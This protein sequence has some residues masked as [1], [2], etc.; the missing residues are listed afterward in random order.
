MAKRN[1]FLD[2]N[3]TPDRRPDTRHRLIKPRQV[4][5][6]PKWCKR[7]LEYLLETG[8]DQIT[9][10]V[11]EKADGH[12]V[13]FECCPGGAFK[14]YARTETGKLLLSGDDAPRFVTTLACDLRMKLKCE[15]R[16]LY[17]GREMGFLEVLSMLKTFQDNKLQNVGK[18]QL[19]ICPFGI[20]SLSPDSSVMSERACS[21]LPRKIVDEM[22]REAVRPD[23]TLMTLVRTTQYQVRLYD[24]DMGKHGL[25]FLSTDGKHTVARGQQEF[26]NYLIAQ[27]DAKGIEGFVLKADPIIFAA[28]PV[29][30]NKYGT[31]DQSAVKVKREFKVT[32]LACRVRDKKLKRNLIFAYGLDTDGNVVYAGEHTKHERLSSMLPESRTAFSFK[33]KQE[34]Q[35]LYTLTRAQLE[36]KKDLM[37]QFKASCTNMSKY[38]F[39]PIGLKIHDMVLMPVDLGT[40]S[41]LQREAEA[42]SHF[43]ATRAAS[44]DYAL[45][46]GRD[47]KKKSRKR[48]SQEEPPVAAAPKRAYREAPA[49]LDVDAFLDAIGE[50]FR[51]PPRKEV[52]PEVVVEVEPEVAVQVAAEPVDHKALEDAAFKEY[53][54]DPQ[55]KPYRVL[56]PVVRVF[57]DE[58]RPEAKKILA[59]KITFFGGT[60]VYKLGPDVRVLVTRRQH[61]RSKL[62]EEHG[63]HTI[64]S[65]PPDMIQGF[66]R[67]C[68]QD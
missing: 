48:K 1:R 30:T 10:T 18:F 52:E 14:V 33:D 56:D 23:S 57:I 54:S 47:E 42:N 3:V 36:Q 64:H 55:R 59:R 35:A 43:R 26:F 51:P 4:R 16:A 7:L 27:A 62:F 65:V 20:Y 15:L 21:F 17:D 22:L 41:V 58:S 61:D 29:V 19:Q 46:I 49:S 67:E 24:M 38:H 37:K 53:T 11:S 25:E 45:A 40:L 68:A 13:I 6:Y 63:V 32:L 34:K 44:N 28:E 66:L 50:Q 39:T 8:K 9:L 60:I 5:E 12:S 2:E 31:R